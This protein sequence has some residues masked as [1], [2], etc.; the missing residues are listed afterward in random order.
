M[1]E[2]KR[3][4]SPSKVTSVDA[5]KEETET[6]PST[7][8]LAD[9][10]ELEGSLQQEEQVVT[11]E[12]PANQEELTINTK[13][14]DKEL[15]T[16]NLKLDAENGLSDK[17]KSHVETEDKAEA[18]DVE[19]DHSKKIPNVKGNTIVSSTAKDRNKE[20]N[21]F[22]NEIEET[23]E[24]EEEVIKAPVES[25]D[26]ESTP[27]HGEHFE[28][29]DTGKVFQIHKRTIK[30]SSNELAKNSLKK[31]YKQTLAKIIDGEEVTIPN[32]KEI[33][34]IMTLKIR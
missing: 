23:M 8:A 33:K 15:T 20:N 12:I 19:L 16:I 6:L 28:D 3:A 30:E 31:V 10:T 13:E 18:N 1:I 34:K 27:V 4:E 2:L 7:T 32:E 25:E 14:S 11:T 17:S 29:N 24:L 9:K 21:D 5:D 26:I 22:K